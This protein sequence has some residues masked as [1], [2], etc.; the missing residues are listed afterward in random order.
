MH[1]NLNIEDK[2]IQLIK[3]G[4][5]GETN[6]VELEDIAYR[7]ALHKTKETRAHRVK[8]YN[9]NCEY[10]VGD[11]IYKEYPGKIPVGSKKYIEMETGV[12]LSVV[13]IRTRYGIN[14]IKLSYD[15][16]SIFKNYTDYLDRQKIELLLPHKQ[17]K[18]YEKPEVLP[19]DIDPRQ[20]QA[21][22][23]RRDFTALKRKLVTV[24][25][26]EADV[27]LI[28]NK[29][30]LKDNLKPLTDSVF[31]KIKEFLNENKKSET[32]EFFI[33]HFARIPPNH[34]D[35]PAYCFALNYH[36]QVNYKIDFQQTQEQ[37]WGKWNLIS[38]IYYTKKN[39]LISDEN[40]LN[41]KFFLRDK[42][43]LPQR[44]KRF[45]ETLFA[46]DGPRYLLTQREI[47]AGAVRLKPGF[48]DMGESIE[49]E[50]V[51]TKMKK[52]Y[53]VY[54]Y[55]DD[56]ILLGL[57]EIFDRYKAL[58][59]TIISFELG[60]DGK[61]H[62]LIRT[63]KKGTISDQIGYVPS[64]KAFKVL[65]EK[66]A[67]PVFV[68]KPM[69][70]ESNV[71]KNL[72]EK[73]AELRKIDTMNKLVHKIFLEFGIKERNYEIHFLRLFHILD[74]IYP[75][76]MRLVEDI[77]LCNP[78]FVPAEK[79]PGVFYLD[80]DAV[81]GI[82]EEEVK[83]QE[84]V[85][86]EDKKRRD[87]VKKQKQEQE[88]RIK[89]EIRRKREERRRKREDEMWEKEKMRRELEQ[90]RLT[91]HHKKKEAQQKATEAQRKAIEAHRKASQPS[92]TS[93]PDSSHVYND[94][95]TLDTPGTH[96]QYET[97]S[98]DYIDKPAV[99]SVGEPGREPQRR[100]KKK[101]PEEKPQGKTRK[102]EKKPGEEHMSKE[103]I[104]VQIELEN[105]K[106]N[107]VE[108]KKP[109]RKDDKKKKIAY[110]DNGGFAGVLA[111]KLDEIVKKD[112]KSI[113]Q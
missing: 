28:S 29:V 92:A 17:I 24:L 104:Q 70:L 63:T 13:E 85:R 95:E 36:M 105:L 51:D 79:L 56:F 110:Q 94:N 45:E 96:D 111:S 109:A 39:S 60:D 108:Q 2:D 90:K 52:S 61:L 43:N 66:I 37:G 83:R 5:K 12:V 62:F 44:R 67:S 40:P 4:L 46:E 27:A 68:S 74:L 7:L 91:E 47:S 57:K 19:E 65:E 100:S 93:R 86:D 20:Q 58:Q 21:P 6:P 41:H 23:E 80:S 87:E 31:D 33:E 77:I 55:K 113:K 53:L 71:F 106:E 16:T 76:D 101:L 102:M 38:V 64:E 69:F 3:D 25:N 72:Y 88:R 99:S 59:A 89:E 50:L 75:F 112:D 32:T 48:F 78:E 14:E 54:H 97:P 11:L 10:K 35:F 9:P 98:P 26:K 42:K 103:D 15:G 30:L 1:V 81:G 22:L 18:P 73:L 84:V 107:L 34:P 8:I 82:E 49:I